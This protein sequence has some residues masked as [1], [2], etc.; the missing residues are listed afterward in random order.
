MSECYLFF[1]FCYY[2]QKYASNSGIFKYRRLF[3]LRFKC[4]HDFQ[5]NLVCMCICAYSHPPTP[6]SSVFIEKSVVHPAVQEFPRL[7]WNLRG[8][9]LCSQ[10]PTTKPYPKPDDSSPQPHTLFLRGEMLQLYTKRKW[11]WA[12]YWNEIHGIH[13]PL[14]LN[15]CMLFLF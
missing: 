13:N 1:M 10:K 11:N 7:L 4:V 14:L 15:V 12:L 2:S 3:T 8:W 9:L 6:W 5:I